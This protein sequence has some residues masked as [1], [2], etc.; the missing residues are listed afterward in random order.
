[1]PRATRNTPGCVLFLLDSSG[2][3]HGAKCD[4]LAKCVNETIQD[5]LGICTSGAEIL[6]RFFLGAIRYGSEVGPAITFDGDA[7][8]L[9]PLSALESL[10]FPADGSEDR[11]WVQPLA[12]GGTPMGEAFRQA[13]EALAEWVQKHPE[14]PRPVVINVTDGQAND[15]AQ[16][17]EGAKKLRELSCND[18]TTVVFNIHITDQSLAPIILPDAQRL[19]EHN[20]GLENDFARHLFEM[21]SELPNE[22]ILVAERLFPVAP[23]KLGSKAF[24]FNAPLK[25]LPKL[26]QVGT[27]PG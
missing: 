2:S 27:L 12:A 24:A 8:I 13:C 6:D 21:S 7:K 25:W 26:F 23:P 5:F 9:R 10:Q 3:M 15:P 17:A 11:Q 16:A 14:S 22:M 19:D 20:F 18:G 1:M 4:S